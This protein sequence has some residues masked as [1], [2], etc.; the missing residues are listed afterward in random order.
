MFYLS[1]VGSGQGFRLDS[2]R[3]IVGRLPLPEVQ[4][5]L[6]DV[7]VSK[8]H[9]TIEAVLDRYVLVRDLSS[10]NGTFVDGHRIKGE[11]RVY[12]GH[13]IGIGSFRLIVEEMATQDV[14]EA[15]T[16]ATHLAGNEIRRW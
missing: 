5:Q 10:L 15:V 6:L 16:P 8:Q 11:A 4:V 13:E 1:I 9:C 7:T 3:K 2:T 12:V 14:L